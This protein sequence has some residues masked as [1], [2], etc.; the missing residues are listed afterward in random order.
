MDYLRLGAL[1]LELVEIPSVYEHV[2]WHRG[3]YL[4]PSLDVRGGKKLG[5]EGEGLPTAI[6]SVRPRV[7]LGPRVLGNI[8]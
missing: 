5:G 2:M 6:Q 7:L 8:I 1:E 4:R 3:Y